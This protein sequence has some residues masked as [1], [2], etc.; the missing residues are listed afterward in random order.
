M[1]NDEAFAEPP[2]LDDVLRQPASRRA[3]HTRRVLVTMTILVGMTLV[4]VSNWARVVAQLF[5]QFPV[6]TLTV[7]S[8]ANWATTT[9]D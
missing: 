8:N 2:N 4:V 1:L 6:Y 7:V 5:P 3:W 9:V